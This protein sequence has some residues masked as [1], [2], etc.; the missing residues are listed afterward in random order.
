MN[1]L[2]IKSRELNEVFYQDFL[3]RRDF[4]TA[5]TVHANPNDRISILIAPALRMKCLRVLRIQLAEGQLSFDKF[6]NSFDGSS[7]KS[8]LE[9][10]IDAHKVLQ[11]ISII[12]T[13]PETHGKKLNEIETEI[14]GM[15][16]ARK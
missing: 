4:I 1:I 14:Q 6:V 9:A 16:D 8:C 5:M 11:K 15:I 12:P 10:L 2:Y 7:G 3:T 13:E